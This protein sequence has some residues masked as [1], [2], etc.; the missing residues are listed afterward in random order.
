ME[1]GKRGIFDDRPAMSRFGS[2]G[3]STL[4]RGSAATAE[5][6]YDEWKAMLEAGSGPEAGDLTR[7]AGKELLAPGRRG[8]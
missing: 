1:Y 6:P 8:G 2:V 5:I 7:K 3:V 4:A